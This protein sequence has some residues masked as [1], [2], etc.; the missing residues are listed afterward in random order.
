[1]AILTPEDFDKLK[2]D[3]EDAGKC[4]NTDA[5]INPRYG[6]PFMSFP[7]VS[8]LGQ[9]GFAAAIQKIENMGGYV[10][11]ASLTELN[12]RV[13][14]F[15]YQLARVQDTGDEYF[16]D[17]AAS[18]SPAW[19][20]TGK[21]W[22]NA[23]KDF[24]NANPLFKPI[25]LAIG[26][27]IDTLGTGIYFV[28][29]DAV[30]AGLLGT[31]PPL[32][33]PRRGVIIS[34]R[35]GTTS[36]EKWIRDMSPTVEVYERSG[37]GQL[38]N[39]ANFAWNPWQK[40]VTTADIFTQNDLKTW[41]SEKLFV[42][43]LIRQNLLDNLEFPTSSHTSDRVPSK[44]INGVTSL[45]VSATTVGTYKSVASVTYTNNGTISHF[46]SDIITKIKAAGFISAFI[47][48]EKWLNASVSGTVSLIQYA[49]D[50]STL[51]NTTVATLGA[52]SSV[53]KVCSVDGVVV[54]AN[55]SRIDFMIRLE[56]TEAAPPSFTLSRPC[57][58]AS[59]RADYYP[60]INKADQIKFNLFPNPAL[61]SNGSSLYQASVSGDELVMNAGQTQ[62][63]Y[64]VPV[65]KYFPIGSTLNWSA[66]GYSN[67][68]GSDGVD[69]TMI[70]K[71]SLGTDI[72][73]LIP[74]R[75][76]KINQWE[77]LTFTGIVPSN[78]ATIRFRF[79]KRTNSSVGKFRNAILESNAEGVKVIEKF[80]A[81]SGATA[82][83]TT[84]Y[85]SPSGSDI[86]GTGSSSS[87]FKTKAKAASIL[88]EF[89]V[90]YCYEGDYDD[91]TYIDISKFKHLEIRALSNSKVR[92]LMTAKTTG[93]VKTAGM[94][95]IYQVVK[96]SKPS[97]W[98]YIHDLPDARTLIDNAKRLPWQRGRIHRMSSTRL[99]EASSLSVLDMA[100]EPSWFWADGILYV[101]T[102][103]IGVDPLTADIR[104]P[105]TQNPAVTGG[106][107]KQV[108]Y[109]SGIQQMYSGA[110]GLNCINLIYCQLDNVSAS[111]NDGQGLALYD[112]QYLKVSMCEVGSNGGDGF[113]MHRQQPNPREADVTY[114][115]EHCW[116]HD[117]YD[118]GDSMHENC[119][120]FYNSSL[121]EFNG[122]RGIATAYGAH[123]VAIGCYARSNGQIFNT[124][125]ATNGE[126]FAVV[127]ETDPANDTGYG[128][129]MICI[130]CVSEDNIQNY[131]ISSA[132]GRFLAMDCI[133][134]N[135]KSTG[136]HRTVSGSL[137][138]IQDCKDTGSVV[139]KSAGVIVNN[140]PLVT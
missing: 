25:T 34:Y 63:W 37:N 65:S 8:R 17:P 101:N 55:C 28:P 131:S 58:S 40:Q 73:V 48:L 50:G 87:P 98:V 53:A 89:G 39:S 80:A 45:N 79:V 125:G 56:G 31:L 71:D 127:G 108:L 64:D 83:F 102:S 51:V 140:N 52:S 96:G 12:T 134:R 69:I 86:A 6:I 59:T 82:G 138:E 61:T 13:P 115:N 36:Y 2:I 32:S 23:A 130:N 67:L 14:T 49:A 120:G 29:S 104:V 30:A 33:P 113:N 128:T 66:E 94:D 20:P 121:F 136:Y 133:S 99:S 21:N 35:S 126:G 10:S 78:A 116:A 109:M 118:D 9:E 81:S 88:G 111:F 43:N 11:A 18:P 105:A 139:I 62:V 117:N 137:M 123:A 129:Q 4:P 135:A 26:D 24:V 75:N 107:G 60:K 97:R 22:L 106:N 92:F 7:M 93:W 47:V 57:I 119:V 114:V 91:N 42:S 5:I 110:N 15:N 95:N 70:F 103:M 19:K 38:S 100:T 27:N 41:L 1:M 112:S 122:D 85:I 132:Q 54:N 77:T 76:T 3:I 90:I 46:D 74:T 84:A 72:G 16:W 124:L 68:A 44:T